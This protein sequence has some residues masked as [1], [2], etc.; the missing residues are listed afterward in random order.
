MLQTRNSRPSGWNEHFQSSYCLCVASDYSPEFRSSYSGR[1]SIR[2]G[3]NTERLMVSIIYLSLSIQSS[4][5]VDECRAELL[6]YCSSTIQHTI[7]ISHLIIPSPW[8]FFAFIR[9]RLEAVACIHDITSTSLG[10]T[11]RTFSANPLATVHAYTA[12]K[13]SG[14]L[15]STQFLKLTSDLINTVLACQVKQHSSLYYL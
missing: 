1:I 2:R 9:S 13:A 4:Q 11:S 15:Q 10:C 3:E 14:V 5:N 8:T 12:T 6:R 7:H